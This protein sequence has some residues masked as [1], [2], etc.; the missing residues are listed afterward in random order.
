MKIQTLVTPQLR[1]AI[2][3]DIVILS[4]AKNLNT[5]IKQ[6]ILRRFAPQNDRVCPVTE[7]LQTLFE[8]LFNSRTYQRKAMLG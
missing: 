4:E 7:G 3:H 5:L 2:V 8:S 1:V 6:E